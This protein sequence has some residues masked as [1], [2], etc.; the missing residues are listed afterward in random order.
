MVSRV[1]YFERSSK[2]RTSGFD[3]ENIGSNPVL[4]AT[5]CGSSMVE[6]GTVNAKADGSSPSHTAIYCGVVQW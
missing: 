4:S 1:F 2:G 6:R 5:M 3:P